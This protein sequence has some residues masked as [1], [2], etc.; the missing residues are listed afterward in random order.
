MFLSSSDASARPASSSTQRLSYVESMSREFRKGLL[1]AGR[2]FT[3]YFSC[4]QWVVQLWVA[5]TILNAASTEKYSRA[6]F[7]YSVFVLM[8][9]NIFF[10]FFF[11][12][13]SGVVDLYY[14][15]NNHTKHITQYFFCGV[16]VR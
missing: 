8:F 2:H 10:V 13:F 11:I 3:M 9:L 12:F 6:I 4:R 15:R 7:C 16:G 5:V 14:S 1:A